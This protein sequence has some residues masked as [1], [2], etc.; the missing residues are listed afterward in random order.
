MVTC[1]FVITQHGERVSIW[2]GVGGKPSSGE[3]VSI[4]EGVGGKPSSGQHVWLDLSK[5]VMPSC[6]RLTRMSLPSHRS[7]LSCGGF[8]Y[9]W[10]I[11]WGFFIRNSLLQ[12]VAQTIWTAHSGWIVRK[13]VSLLTWTVMG[14]GAPADG[15]QFATMDIACNPESITSG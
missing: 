3:R 7:C 1:N 8:S 13:S 9:L 6:T 4:W 11:L 14:S 10:D 5:I 2:E 12:F 15:H